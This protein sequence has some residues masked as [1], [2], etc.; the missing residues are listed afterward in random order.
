MNSSS[1][2]VHLR[3][4]FYSFRLV[5][6]SLLSHVLFASRLEQSVPH[7]R[8]PRV[9]APEKDCVVMKQLALYANNDEDCKTEDG[10]MISVGDLARMPCE[11]GVVTRRCVEGEKGMTEWEYCSE[12][13]VKS[14]YGWLPF[15]LSVNGVRYDRIEET[16]GTGAAAEGGRGGVVRV[17]HVLSDRRGAVLFHGVVRGVSD[18]RVEG[19]S[20]RYEFEGKAER[21]CEANCGD[22][23]EGHFRQLFEGG[24]L[25]A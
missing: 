22:V 7:R 20:D 14:G 10:T 3:R 15:G 21:H 6:G 19:Q 9:E 11:K 8:V 25:C 17:L 23:E 4:W 18:E 13:K 16:E 1:Q 2:A 5:D 24:V 12:G